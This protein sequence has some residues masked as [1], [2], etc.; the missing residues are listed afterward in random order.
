M[1][2]LGSVKAEYEGWR[3]YE[4]LLILRIL[5]VSKILGNFRTIGMNFPIAYGKS[6]WKDQRFHGGS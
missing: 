1:K 6:N 5:P 2:I 4:K 3:I